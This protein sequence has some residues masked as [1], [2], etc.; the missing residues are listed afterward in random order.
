MLPVTLEDVAELAQVSKATVSRVINHVPL[1]NKETRRR[2]LEAIE[3][4]GYSPNAQ[5][6]SL[7]TRKTR[8]IALLTSEVTN[9]VHAEI[10]RGVE[11]V[12]NAHGYTMF[13]CN[14]DDRTDKESAY[15]DVLYQQRVEG[16]VFITAR[17]NSTDALLKAR[18]KRL[19][20]VLCS[21]I[22]PEEDFDQVGAD[23][24]LGGTIATR[25]LLSLGH[26]RIAFVSG[27]AG[28]SGS[29]QRL[30]GYK[31]A[32]S[33][34]NIEPLPDLVLEGNADREGGYK[35]GRSLLRLSPRVTAVF[36]GNDLMAIGVME[37]IHDAGL[38]VPEDIA[39][40][41]FDDIP[42]ASLYSLGLTTIHYS[43][44][45]LGAIAGKLLLEKLSSQ[46]RDAPPQNIILPAKLVI[47]S[48]CGY[49]LRSKNAP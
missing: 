6:R 7:V 24:Y 46:R 49:H 8:T 28:V 16:L 45:E 20:F 44:Y 41:G 13:L 25:H 48:S 1:V 35:A 36:A 23:D 19:P 40:V 29:L 17:V 32:L 14:T 5:A 11:D 4:L 38:R 43:K 21:R 3:E 27:R 15:I 34:Y 33:E 37:A 47:R 42:M 2:V 31:A 12:A 26:K 22:L 9:P 39:V 10:A 30:E 18:A